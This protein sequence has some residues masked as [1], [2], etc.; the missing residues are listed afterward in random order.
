VSDVV[1]IHVHLY[2]GEASA[3]PAGW[4]AA[5]GEPGWS[6]VVAPPGRRGIQGWSD[7]G[8]LIAHMDE[9]GV[10]TCVLLGW[11]WERQDTC[12]LQ[13][14]WHQEW[15]RR[16]P[17][18]LAAFAAVQ[19]A[20]GRRAVHSL[21]R[22]LD[23]GLVGVG[24]LLPQ[25]QGYGIDDPA[26]REVLELAGSRGAP[27]NLH[28]TDPAA[29]A[30]AGPPTP[31]GDFARLARDHPRTRLILAHWGGGMAFRGLPGGEGLPHNLFFDTAASPLLY[32]GEVFR[33]AADRVGAD[34]ILYGSDYPIL[35]HFRESRRPELAR[36]IRDIR[37]S[38]LT[39]AELGLV[40]GA[41]ARRLLPGLAPRG[42]AV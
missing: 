4:A 29:G 15:V 10:A 7:P 21:E 28:A 32:G 30:R 5:H 12:D 42:K 36:F 40:L 22:A 13:N 35:L 27:V 31:L 34:R 19:P 11:Y 33:Q 38:G 16:H 6:A 17:G 37:S 24:E 26:F 23:G 8:A 2:P 3:D 25:A 9:A 14:G 39:Q 1:D 20:E 41:N 18:R